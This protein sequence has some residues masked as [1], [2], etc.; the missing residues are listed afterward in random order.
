M[1][2]L[3]TLN[4]ALSPDYCVFFPPRTLDIHDILRCRLAGATSYTPNYMRTVLSKEIEEKFLQ[5][6]GKVDTKVNTVYFADSPV[7]EP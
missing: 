2:P 3:R 7:Y 6:K 1:S 4:A 5:S